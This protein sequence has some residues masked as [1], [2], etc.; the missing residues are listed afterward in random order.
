M[1]NRWTL[2]IVVFAFL[3]VGCAALTIEPVDY[4][5]GLESVLAGCSRRGG[6]RCPQNPF[7]QRRAALCHGIGEC[8]PE[9]KPTI[10]VIRNRQGHYFVTAPSVQTRLR[11]QSR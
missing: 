6:D 4:S 5:W 3:A 11:F 1:A 10:R 7:F 8:A 9:G 2:W